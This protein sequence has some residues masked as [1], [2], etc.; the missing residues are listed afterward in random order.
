MELDGHVTGN[1][2]TYSV[3]DRQ[4]VVLPVGSDPPKLVALGLPRAP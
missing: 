3:D 2:I 1:P 4:L